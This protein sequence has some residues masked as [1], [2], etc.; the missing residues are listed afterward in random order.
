MHARYV[1][2]TD[3][4]LWPARSDFSP[5]RER[6][7]FHL[8]SRS[9][10]ARNSV[11]EENVKTLWRDGVRRLSVSRKNYSHVLRSL[12][13]CLYLPP[14]NRILTYYTLFTIYDEGKKKT[15]RCYAS[16]AVIL[17]RRRRRRRR[18]FCWSNYF[19]AIY[20]NLLSYIRNT[21]PTNVAPNCIHYTWDVID[22]CFMVARKNCREKAIYIIIISLNSLSHALLFLGSSSRWAYSVIPKNNL[23]ELKIRRSSTTPKLREF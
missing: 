20:R 22:W 3:R 2:V 5:R 19:I 6:N 8:H 17:S 23:F 18:R 1:P 11:E 4:I 12:S 13:L 21:D 10:L 9:P 7:G 16:V 15:I 14:T